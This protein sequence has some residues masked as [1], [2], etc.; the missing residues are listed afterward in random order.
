MLPGSAIQV[1]GM[2]WWGG[3]G[4]GFKGR[5]KPMEGFNTSLEFEYFNDF[6]FSS[7]LYTLQSPQ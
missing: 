5:L 7:I 4:V 2:G 3:G 1:C 6:S